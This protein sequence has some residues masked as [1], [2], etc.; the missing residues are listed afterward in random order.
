MEVVQP[1]PLVEMMAEELK[2]LHNELTDIA[3]KLQV[4]L[5][6]WSNA[7]MGGGRSAWFVRQW[8]SMHARDNGTVVMVTTPDIRRVSHNVFV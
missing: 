8:L 5:P 7:I 6:E 1:V 4:L 3:E 2:E